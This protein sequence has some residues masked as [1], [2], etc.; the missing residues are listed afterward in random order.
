VNEYFN[1]ANWDFGETF[2]FTE[3]STYIHQKLG[4]AIGSIVI[5]PKST[6]GILGEMFQVKA[7]PNELFVNTASVNDIEIISRLDNQ[8]LRI[9]R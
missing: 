5:L 1:V 3:L 8:T 4:S 7:E 2:Y 9:D 6:T